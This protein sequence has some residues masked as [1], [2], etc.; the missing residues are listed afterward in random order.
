MRKYIRPVAIGLPIVLVLI[1][2]IRPK[3]NL[4]VA[5]GPNEISHKYAVPAK[6]HTLLVNACYN[7]HSNHTRYPWY[8]NVQPIGWWL[9]DHINSGKRHVNFS[10]FGTYGRYNAARRLDHIADQVNE[11]DMPLESYTW[12]HPKA[13]LTRKQRDE[14]VDWA[15]NLHHQLDPD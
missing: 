11:G 8:A 7:C 1:Q 5:E 15:Q 14:I 6:V 10:E 12:M 3:R 13:R 2:F 9:A 4:G